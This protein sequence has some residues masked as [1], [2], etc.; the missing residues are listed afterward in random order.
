MAR[1]KRPRQHGRVRE[2]TAP[3]YAP[4]PGSSALNGVLL[5]S[6][7]IIELLRDNAK[8]VSS[9]AALAASGIPTYCTPVSWAEVYEGLRAGEEPVT[10]SFFEAR[11]EV[12]LDSRIGRQAG[13]YLARYARSH[14]LE[15]PDALIA[16]AAATTGLRLWTLNQRHYPMKDVRFFEAEPAR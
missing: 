3:G 10:D 7:V 11:G 9:A 2:T 12:V 4:A 16:A 14:G 1:P 6:D 15:V 13:K 8:I 5:D